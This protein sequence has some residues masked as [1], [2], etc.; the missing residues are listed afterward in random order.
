MIT[1]MHSDQNASPPR[2]EVI[3]SVQ[4]RRRWPTAEKIRLVEETMQP[5][6]SV[7]Y[8]ARRAGVAPS[9]LF[10][11]RRRMLE[12]G[13]QAVQ[14]DEDVVG[15]SRVRELERRVRELERLLGR[16][17]MEVE[18]LKEALDVARGKKTE[19]AAAIME[20][21]EGRFAMKAVADTLAVARSNLIERVSR[22][23]KSRRP[24]RK[25]GDDELLALIRR[26]VDERPTYGYRRIRRLIN[27]QR[28]ANGKPPVNGK[29]VLRIMQANKLT[30]E[31]HTGRRPGRTHD[32]VVIALRSNIRWCSDHFELACR[33]GEIVRVLFAIDACDREV[34]G[35]L[36][37]SAGISGEMVRDL[38][39]ACVE[40]RF[41]ISKAAHPV[42]WL[43][44]N[45]S[46]YIAKDT[47]DTATALGL[48]LC[49]TPV[50]SPESNGIAEAF[51]KTF[52]RDY[53]RLSILPDA[54]TVI[55]LLPAWFEDYNEVHPHS[56]LKFLSPREFLRLSA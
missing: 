56:G 31:R 48:K 52:K 46:A 36:A 19:L 9:L 22:R 3:T 10:N 42:E 47:L 14:A 39:V 41:G 40:R 17:T 11:W 35:W 16:K 12:G 38:M 44:D 54:E 2:V 24:Y 5:G 53:A 25:A 30:L 6:M 15:T 27:R 23:A 4:R 28:K 34:M 8:V 49:F 1:T 55:A 45:G 7:S 18:I 32:G 37:T 13:L 20:R 43:S 51:V 33:N 50:R 29:R 26:L 21:S